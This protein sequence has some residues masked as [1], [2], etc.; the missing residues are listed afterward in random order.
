[1][2]TDAPDMSGQLSVQ[3]SVLAQ[4]KLSSLVNEYVEYLIYCCVMRLSRRD[5]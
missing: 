2:F 3:S 5:C 1:M 4:F